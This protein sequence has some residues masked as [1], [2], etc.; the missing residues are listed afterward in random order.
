MAC[1]TSGFMPGIQLPYAEWRLYARSMPMRR[2][3]GDG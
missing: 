2:P 3:V 1:W